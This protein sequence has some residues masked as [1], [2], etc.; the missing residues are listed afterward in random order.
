MYKSIVIIGLGSLGGFFAENVSKLKGLQ[1][2]ILIDPDI[3]ELKNI[4]KSIYKR[5]D[6][7]R[8]KVDVIK[9]IID[10]ENLEIISHPIEY[11]EGKIYL[12]DNDLIVDCRDEICS[13]EGEIDVRFYIS[14]KTLMI[15][16]AKYHKVE[17][18][19]SGKYGH[20]LTLSQLSWAGHM[21]A[22]YID[23][24]I[25]KD[26]IKRQAIFQIRIDIVRREAKKAIKLHDAVPDIVYDFHKG[27]Y[28]I[29]N[30]SMNLPKLTEINK[31]KE[32]K[33]IIGQE[34]CVA[35]NIQI[36]GK[37]EI[38]NYNDAVKTLTE[39]VQ[40]IVP[41]KEHYTI[42]VNDD[43]LDEVYIELLPDTGAA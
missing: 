9:E 21:A 10:N 35:C 28:R 33:V 15:D 18:K 26:Y 29:R 6:I 12:P 19:T 13:R 1:T 32:L 17:S 22:E 34:D 3:I 39:I 38:V 36:I 7:G 16:C 2:L 23:E 37:N 11:I 30:L 42:K 31:T 8:F 40:S 4:G 5:R 20:L 25:L 27:D 14:Y 41:L 43:N 24:T